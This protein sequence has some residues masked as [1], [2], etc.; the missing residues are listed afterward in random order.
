MKFIKYV[1]IIF[2]IAGILQA[3]SSSSPKNKKSA[4][5]GDNAVTLAAAGES[6]LPAGPITPYPYLQN[7]PAINNAAAQQFSNATRAMRNKQ[8]AQAEAL[9]QQIVAQHKNFSGAWLNL[10]LVYHAQKDNKRADQAFT[11]AISANHLNLDAYN[12][13]AIL[14][15]EQGRFNE[16]EINYRKALTVWPFHAESH[17][18]IGI[19]YD[20]YLGKNAE[21]LAHFEAYRQLR[22]DNDKQV[23]GWIADLQRR[24]GIAPKP[25]APPAE[26]QPVTDENPETVE[27]AE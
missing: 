21:A 18:N 25:K 6:I 5:T 12:Q 4:K 8:W 19:L 9:L 22:G 24:L 2:F 17:K 1:L 13:L 20:L 16:A 15:R 3:C 26:A 10:G 11:Q 23:I 7:K 27:V 14:Q